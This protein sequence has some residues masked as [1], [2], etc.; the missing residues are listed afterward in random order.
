MAD[1]AANR[2]DGTGADHF[3]MKQ[4]VFV[5][6]LADE[7][8]ASAQINKCNRAFG[9]PEPLSLT[10]TMGWPA[11]LRSRARELGALAI[12]RGFRESVQVGLGEFVEHA[13][14]AELMPG[15]WITGPVKRIHQERN[16]P[17]GILVKTPDGTIPD[18]VPEDTSLVL[19]TAKGLVVVTGCGHA[20]V[21]NIVEYA[22]EAVRPA[23]VY[24]VVGGLHLFPA[25]APALDWT[26][27]KLRAGVLY[28]LYERSR[29]RSALEEA[30][31]AYQTA[32][33]AWAQLAQRAEAVY[34]RDI[35]F[36]PDRHQRGHWL[37]RLPAMDQDIAK[38][39]QLLEKAAETPSPSA[40]VR[41][42]I[43]KALQAVRVLLR[44]PSLPCRPA[45]SWDAR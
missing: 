39:A 35:T 41:E 23:P 10:A 34:V 29:D 28:A 5:P 11:T 8:A 4:Y 43:Q 36:G 24:A 30:L 17:P 22:R 13:G 6:L 2:P 16:Y 19:D 15:V 20:G 31:K 44:R 45:R 32:R 3:P 1:L 37:D 7:P 9:Q 18:E 33:A 26:A 38:M 27:G 14:P 42:W 40:A 21:V 25:D 12:C